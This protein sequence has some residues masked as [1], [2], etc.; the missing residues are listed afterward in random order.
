MEATPGRLMIEGRPGSRNASEAD[1]SRPVS[2]A[3]SQVGLRVAC[4]V[5]VIFHSYKIEIVFHLSS[6]PKHVL[7]SFP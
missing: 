4:H 5:F 6:L 3:L 2:P 1:F 7:L